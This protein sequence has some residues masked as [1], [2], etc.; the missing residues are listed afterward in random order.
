[1]VCRSTTQSGTPR[2]S[3]T[4]TFPGV[5]IASVGFRTDLMIRVFE[6]SEVTDHSEYLTVRTPA[7][8]EFWWGNFLLLRAPAAR[9]D[10]GRWLPVFAAEFPAAGHIA[11]G[12][13]ITT[14]DGIDLAG[15]AAAG[16]DVERDTVL[17]AQALREPPHPN[18]AASIRQLAGDGDW[19]QSAI[20]QGVCD[21]DDGIATSHAFT[22][23]RNRTRRSLTEAGHGS[24]FGAFLDGELVSQLGVI[25]GPDRI[26]RYQD[27]GTHPAARRRGLAGTLVHH[28]GQYALSDLGAKTLVI[29]A[30]PHESAISVYRS[31]GFTDRESQVRAQRSRG[32]TGDLEP[33]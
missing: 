13:D 15:F 28:A 8:P 30:D 23:T 33:Q 7:N 14:G 1:V 18:Q 24:W 29:V 6:G 27:V 5:D 22:D 20:L 11:L 25:S 32:H 19:Q 16:L 2:L 3:K 4:V 10:A 9:G 26:A 31:A 17:T 21:A 12:L